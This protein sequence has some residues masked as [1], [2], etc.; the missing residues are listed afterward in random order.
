MLGSS[1]R[2][3]DKVWVPR[4]GPWT[5]HS[6]EPSKTTTYL[7][8][9]NQKLLNKREE[10]PRMLLRL[11]FWST[12]KRR[13]LLGELEVLLELVR[14]SRLPM[15]TTT[16]VLIRKSSRKRCT[17]SESVCIQTKLVLPSI[18]S[19]EMAVVRSITMSS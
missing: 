9:H 15:T 19:I 2:S 10:L 18:S 11:R 4:D 17:T 5:T 1:P 7:E 12:Y 16:R 3:P 14:S 13:L 6:Q 8:D